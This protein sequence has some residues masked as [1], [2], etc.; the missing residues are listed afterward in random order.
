MAVETRATGTPSVAEI[1]EAMSYGPAPESPTAARE[2]LAAHAPHLGMFIGGEWHAPSEGEYFPSVNPATAK[3]LIEV[4]Q[5][6]A[7]DV[8]AAVRA[9]R[10]AFPAWSAAP[11]HVRARYLY[12]LARQVQK[13]ARLFAVLESLDNG[14]PIRETRDIDIPLVARPFY[15]HAG[16]APLLATDH[17]VQ[18][19]ARV[20]GHTSPWNL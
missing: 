20:V 10:E 3:P 12:A 11:G 19:P 4:A 1:F 2:W 17:P 16:W 18:R 9:A 5:G 6:S 13:H 7:A 15:H 14:K 8:D